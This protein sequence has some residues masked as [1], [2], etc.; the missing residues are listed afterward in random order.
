[1]NKTNEN[2]D[3]LLLGTQLHIMN[4]A[5]AFIRP[6]DTTRTE[7]KGEDQKRPMWF[8]S[9]SISESVSQ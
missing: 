2:K 4:T 6:F 1:M 5:I 8:F 9:F 3:I 7:Q